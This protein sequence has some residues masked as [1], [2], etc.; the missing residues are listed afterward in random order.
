[1]TVRVHLFGHYRDAIPA[2]STAAGFPVEIAP[3]GTP[4]DVAA[5]LARTDERLADLTSRT[6]VAVN[7]EFAP[8]DTPLADGDEIAFLP[9]MSGG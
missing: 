5:R 6:R 7:A 1:M 8:A 4:I 3:G 9:P 2:D